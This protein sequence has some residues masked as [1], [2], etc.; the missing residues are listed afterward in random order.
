MKLILTTKTQTKDKFQCLYDRDLYTGY[1]WFEIMPKHASKAA[2]ALQLK[3]MLGCNRLVCF[4]DGKNDLSMF[5]I[6]DECYA[7][8]NAN[9]VLKAIATDVIESNEEDGVAKWLLAHC[10]L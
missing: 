2:A 4:G 8:A 10:N 3:Q 7:V 1:P 5:E 9:P 6:A